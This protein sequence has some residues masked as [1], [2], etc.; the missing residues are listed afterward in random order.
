M[1]TEASRKRSGNVGHHAYGR[2]VTLGDGTTAFQPYTAPAAV[3]D[4]NNTTATPLTASATYTGIWSRC[5]DGMTVSMKTDQP[6]T[7]FFDFSNDAVNADSTF[8]VQGF[9]VAANVHEYHNA[10]VNGRYCRVRLVNDADGDQTFLRLY[11][12]FGPFS[13]GNSALNQSISIDTDAI[14]TR[15][16][17]FQDEVRRGLRS[18]VAGFTKFGFRLNLTAAAGY[19]TVWATTGNFTPQDSAETWNVTYDN[20]QDG[21]GQ[22]GATQLV[23][24]YIDADGAVATGVHVL[25]STGSDT[26][27]FSGFGINRV[28]V[29]ASGTAKSNNADITVTSS[30]S[31]LKQAV[32]PAGDSVTEQ[33]IYVT[34]DNTIAIGKYVW[35]NVGNGS[36]GGNPKVNIRGRVY[37]RKVTQTFY[38]VFRAIVNTNTEQTFQFDESVG[39]RL[40]PTDVIIFE[41]DTDT[42]GAEINIRFGVNEYAN[43]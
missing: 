17:D 43:V 18:G 42:N 7:L 35:I 10:K 16:T 41:A 3:V 29:L 37:N 9:R 8:P 34:P 36:G 28:A 23:F 20:A 31:G 40:D 15:P 1:A 11:T 24:T 39:F 5:S 32:V 6:G 30:V 13:N 22:T 14:T 21:A 38:T 12:Y 19:E 27:S 25:G 26:T 4:T 2:L 33:A